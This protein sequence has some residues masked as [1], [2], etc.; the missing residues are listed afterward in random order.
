MIERLLSACLSSIQCWETGEWNSKSF[1][2]Q[3]PCSEMLRCSQNWKTHA[4]I[5]I[6]IYIYLRADIKVYFLTTSK[7]ALLAGFKHM[8]KIWAELQINAFEEFKKKIYSGVWQKLMLIYRCKQ[9]LVTCS[10]MVCTQR[11]RLA[12]RL[13]SCGFWE[14]GRSSSLPPSPPPSY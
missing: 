10:K 12:V 8:R 13:C 1:R 11:C 2:A 3:K 5:Y 9:L 7:H 4:D 6:Y 14:G